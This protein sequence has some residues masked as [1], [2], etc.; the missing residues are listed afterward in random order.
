MSSRR[1]GTGWAPYFFLGPFLAI[2][3]IFG[4]FPIFFSLYLMFHIWDPVQGLGS[5]EYVG[6]ENLTFALE[7]PLMWTSLENTI[8]LAVA[9]GVPQHLVAIPL[10]YLINEYLGRYRDVAMGA[11]F[12][13]YI[14]ST[15][16]IS[17]M[18]TTLFSTDYGA[19]NA[20]L[21][22]LAAWEPL[23]LIVP[24]ENIDWLGKPETVKPVLAFVV[25]WRYVGFNTILYVA[26]LQ[27]IPKDLYEAARI[28]GAKEFKI[29]WFI[30]LPQLKPMMYFGVI[31]SLI[32]GLQLFEE[33]F[34]ITGGRGGPEYSG[35]TTAMYMY[36][37]AF[38]FND[39]GLAS[40]ISWL[41]FLVIAVLTW[42]TNRAFKPKGG[43]A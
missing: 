14:T 22:S 41:L 9:S 10:A 7:D 35:M 39:Y 31:L 42:L 25:F 32:G 26:A 1:I 4:I 38:E 29:F 19:V 5:M 3:L 33:P 13:P 23:S 12:V 30:T 20:A 6:L 27:S 11:Y 8:W 37:T 2:F 24:A 17:I 43:L 36:R 18:F 34:I 15:V 28:D 40:A 16:A 21:Q